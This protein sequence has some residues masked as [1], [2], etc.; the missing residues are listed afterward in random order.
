MI[1]MSMKWDLVSTSNPTLP[2]D[3]FSAH[4]ATEFPQGARGHNQNETPPPKTSSANVKDFLVRDWHPIG[5]LSDQKKA[6][7]FAEP[8]KKASPTFPSTTI[9][10]LRGACFVF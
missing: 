1:F 6:S 3:C 9:T 5:M 10:K 2:R 8:A 7:S 4:L